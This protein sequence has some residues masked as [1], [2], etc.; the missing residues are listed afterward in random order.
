MA[1]LIEYSLPPRWRAHHSARPKSV[2]SCW[3]LCRLADRRKESMADDRRRIKRHCRSV[4]SAATRSA[5][6]SRVVR[7]AQPPSYQG[8]GL[9]APP[10]VTTRNLLE[11]VL[12]Q[13]RTVGSPTRSLDGA[14]MQTHT[15]A[16]LDLYGELCT[17]QGR[18]GRADKLQYFR[19]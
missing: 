4:Q 5:P 13:A 7:I 11:M 19:S 15:K 10:R 12:R 8:A 14:S 3:P 2:H 6:P 9:P 17:G 1:T 16:M 18:I